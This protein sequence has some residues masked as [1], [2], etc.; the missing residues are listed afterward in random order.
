MD[1]PPLGVAP[2]WFFYQQRMIELTACICRHMEYMTQHRSED[3]SGRYRSIA[4]WAD[5]LK[6]LATMEARY[7]EEKR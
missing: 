6:T 2:H 3:H 4:Q 1:R 5:E 7:G